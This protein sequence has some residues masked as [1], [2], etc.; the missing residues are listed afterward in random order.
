MGVEQKMK[1][2]I[3]ED[4]FGNYGDSET[5]GVLRA[6]VEPPTT[7]RLLLRMLYH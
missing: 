4:V 3:N 5:I 7:F 1:T 6:E 2:M